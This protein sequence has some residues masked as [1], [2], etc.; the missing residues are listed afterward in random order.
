MAESVRIAGLSKRDQLELREAGI[1]PT[2]VDPEAPPSGVTLHHEPVTVLTVS[3]VLA[4]Q[5]LF[6]FTA[7]LL[8]RRE[9]SSSTLTMT[10]PNGTTVALSV[11]SASSTPP[12]AQL[13]EKVAGAFKIPVD[14]LK[15][16]VAAL[17]A[18]C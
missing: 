18:S 17:E 7:W 10:L 1:R 13:L 6:A 14:D 12:S 2:E 15:D 5:S 16:G 3:L 9:R 8:K 11:D 4:S